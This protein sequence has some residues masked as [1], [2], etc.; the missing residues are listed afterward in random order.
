M[1]RVLEDSRGMRAST[2]PAFTWS[3]FSTDRMASTAQVVAGLAPL[4]SWTTSPFSSRRTIRGL[5]LG[6]LGLLLPVDHDPVGDTGG[7]VGHLAHRRALDQVDVVGRALALGDDRLG[8]GVPFGQAGALLELG[9]FLDQHLGAVRHLV[10]GALA[11]VLV[12][13]DEFAVPAHDTSWPSEL[14]TTFLLRICKTPSTEASTLDCSPPPWAAPPMWKVRMVSCV[15][16]SPIDCAAMTP[17]AS[18]M[19][20]LVPRARSRP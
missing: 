12:G 17:T 1:S 19:L 9:V 14:S 6:S 18:P 15:P 10:A 3:P 16:G 11:A 8:V 5:Q 20:T 4:A 13:H 7:L 2:S